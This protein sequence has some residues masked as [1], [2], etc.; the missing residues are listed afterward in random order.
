MRPLSPNSAAGSSEEKRGRKVRWISV[1][2]S[3]VTQ[4]NEADARRYSMANLLGIGKVRVKD[5]NVDISGSRALKR[6]WR[7]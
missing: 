5:E 7:R 1:V 3:C 4:F 6:P 2:R